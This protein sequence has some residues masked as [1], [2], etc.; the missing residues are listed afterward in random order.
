MI[1]ACCE[2]VFVAL[3]IQHEMR[4][5]RI[6]LSSVICP[7][8][9]NVPR[10]PINGTILKKKSY[11]AYSYIVL[12]KWISNYI[13]FRTASGFCDEGNESSGTAEGREFTL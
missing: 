12:L 3:G 1:I 2:C 8:L 13:C 4:M 10:Y 9:Q 5:R 6:V 7:A 11:W